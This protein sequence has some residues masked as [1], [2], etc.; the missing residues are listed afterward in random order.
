MTKK[1]GEPDDYVNS[2][3][4]VV[5]FPFD[6]HL[7]FVSEN[8][9]DTLTK[10]QQRFS[11]RRVNRVRTERKGFFRV[12]LDEI[13]QAVEEIK[14]DGVLKNVHPVKTVQAYEYYKTQAIERKGKQNLNPIENEIA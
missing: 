8:A 2:M 3:N 5:P 9:L 14:Q 11:D 10:L 13:I 4:P 1:S 6:I 12:S 7:R